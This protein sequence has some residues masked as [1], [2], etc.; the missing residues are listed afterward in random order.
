[1]KERGLT[2]NE[3][4]LALAHRGAEAL[5]GERRAAATRERLERAVLSSVPAEGLPSPDAVEEA[6]VEAR[7][8]RG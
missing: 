3:A 5:E 4:L 7:G 2:R 1:M 8:G 6:M